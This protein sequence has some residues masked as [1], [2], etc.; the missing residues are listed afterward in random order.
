MLYEL[1]CYWEN[2]IIVHSTEVVLLSPRITEAHLQIISI[3]DEIIIYLIYVKTVGEVLLINLQCV[4]I[5]Y[6]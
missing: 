1:H 3:F 2:L 4:E 6:S 5:F